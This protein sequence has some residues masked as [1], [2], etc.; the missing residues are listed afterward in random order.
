MDEDLYTKPRQRESDTDGS[1]DTN[2]SGK[3]SLDN[4]F[5]MVQ[6][7][8]DLFDVMKKDDDQYDNVFHQEVFQRS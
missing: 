4:I 6:N 5:D 2:S 3:M 8:D 1:T 7:N